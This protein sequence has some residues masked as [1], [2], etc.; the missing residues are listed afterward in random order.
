MSEVVLEKLFQPFEQGA[1]DV[2]KRYGGLGLGMAISRALME[3]QGGSIRAE[4]PGPGMGSTFIVAL[5]AVEKPVSNG[6]PILVSEPPRRQ[7]SLEILVVEDDE[8]TSRVLSRL[9]QRWGHRVTVGAT[10]AEARALADTQ[11]FDVILSDIGLP[12]G[13]GIEMIKHIRQR[14]NALAI[15]LSGF[16]MEADVAECKAAGFNEHLTKPINL[17][18]LE[19]LIQRV[20]A[21]V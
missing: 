13:T 10:V 9:I 4:S 17:Q 11:S 12:D 1:A 8:D 2:V 16:G 6:E 18:R 3:A 21:T 20:D 14:S 15:A 19:M 7:R 5:P